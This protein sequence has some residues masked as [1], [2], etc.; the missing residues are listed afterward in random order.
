MIVI[1]TLSSILDALCKGVFN[2]WIIAVDKV[3]LAELNDQWGFAYE[4]LEFQKLFVSK[5]E[6]SHLPTARAPSTAM[7][8]CR[9]AWLE[10]EDI[11]YNRWEREKRER[12]RKLGLF[13]DSCQGG[14]FFVCKPTSW[15]IECTLLNLSV[16]FYTKRQTNGWHE[17]VVKG[18]DRFNEKQNFFLCQWCWMIN[19]VCVSVCLLCEYVSV[20]CVC[21]VLIA[22]GRYN[23]F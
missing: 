8:L 14:E 5:V 1:A 2:S 9:V 23:F 10:E 22:V 4:R 17:M 20:L 6:A 21:Y 7:R 3:I 13:L 19:G 12:E 15:P 18:L 16:W 11:L